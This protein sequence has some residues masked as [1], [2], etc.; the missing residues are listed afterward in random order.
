MKWIFLLLTL[1]AEAQFAVGACTS[2]GQ[3]WAW[4]PS[5]RGVCFN[6]TVRKNV[7]GSPDKEKRIE[8]EEGKGYTFTVNNRTV[9]LPNYG[10]YVVLPIGFSWSPRSDA[11]FVNDGEG[12]GMNSILRVFRLQGSGL[13]ELPDPNKVI[14]AAFRK[15]PGCATSAADPAVW[16]I[17]WSKDGLQIFAYA[18]ATVN[19][20][21]GS[22]GDLRGVVLNAR[23]GSVDHWYSESDARRVFRG[24]LPH[25]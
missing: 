4:N 22:Q 14:A 11:F 3:P 24:L 25:D 2:S 9:A 8:V 15:D 13:A 18:I 7:F 20:P 23:T 1:C 21:C 5:I 17:G 10:K 16:G 6:G 12:S 19:N